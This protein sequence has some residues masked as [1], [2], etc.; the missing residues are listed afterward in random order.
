MKVTVSLK[1]TSANPAIQKQI[2]CKAVD[3]NGN[4]VVTLYNPKGKEYEPYNKSFFPEEIER[5]LILS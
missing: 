2:T 3:V 1:R 4:G 5:I